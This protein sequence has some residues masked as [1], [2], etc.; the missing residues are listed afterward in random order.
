MLNWIVM[1]RNMLQMV[2][3]YS[4]QQLVFGRNPEI[5]ILPGDVSPSMTEESPDLTLR[6]TL[7][8]AYRREKFETQN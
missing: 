4:P 8:Y 5:T 7:E 2:G 1:A 3:G 6:E